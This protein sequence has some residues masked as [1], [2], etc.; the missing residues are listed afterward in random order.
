MCSA[1]MRDLL[2]FHEFFWL[3]PHAHNACV[4]GGQSYQLLILWIYA[5][6]HLPAHETE[7]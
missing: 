1:S 3:A 5:R 4:T 6:N 2:H 7:V